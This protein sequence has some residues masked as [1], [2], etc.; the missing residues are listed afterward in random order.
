MWGKEANICLYKTYLTLFLGLVIQEPLSSRGVCEIWCEALRWVTQWQQHWLPHNTL[1]RFGFPAL[2][3]S[4]E[5]RPKKA[6]WSSA[7]SLNTLVLDLTVLMLSYWAG[8][9]NF[10]RR[11]LFCLICR[12][13]EFQGL[14][15]EVISFLVFAKKR[16]WSLHGALKMSFILLLWNG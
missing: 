13:W 10:W 5:S 2:W 11:R 4:F 3:Q 7:S 9:L 12:L 8:W 16:W 6:S 15:R 14:Q 1:W